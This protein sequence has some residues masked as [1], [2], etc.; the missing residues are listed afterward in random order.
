M[1]P[2][3]RRH[4]PMFLNVYVSIC[5]GRLRQSSRL[6]IIGAGG[7]VNCPPG[8]TVL[9]GGFRTF[10][11]AVDVQIDRPFGNGWNVGVSNPTDSSS[12]L[13]IYALCQSPYLIYRTLH[14]HYFLFFWFSDSLHVFVILEITSSG[15]NLSEI[16]TDGWYLLTY[17]RSAISK[18]C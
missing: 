5:S 12:T 15:L 13:D 3:A 6:D 9:S 8:T 16:L 14:H 2:G 17:T 10:G 18:G 1:A 7:N 4:A 11:P